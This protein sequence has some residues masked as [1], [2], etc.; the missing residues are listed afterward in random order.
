[1]AGIGWKS[2]PRAVSLPADIC[3]PYSPPLE[4]VIIPSAVAIAAAASAA[5]RA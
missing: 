1:M 2:N 5:M 4:D 3:I